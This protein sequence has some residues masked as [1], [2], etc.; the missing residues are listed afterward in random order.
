M[1]PIG[2]CAQ[3]ACIWET[4]ARNP[5][6]VHRQR[7]FEDVTY[8]DFLLSAAA[9]APVLETAGSRPVGET[10]LLGVMATRKVVQ[11]NTNLGILLLLAP[12]AAFS[13]ELSVREGIPRV[14]ET[15][16]VEDAVDVYRAIRLADP[17]GLGQ[18]AKQ[19]LRDDPTVNLREAMGLA[20]DRD[21]VARQY[22]NGFHEVLEVAL[23]ILSTGLAGAPSLE[24]ALVYCHVALLA[25][26][27][28]TLIMRKR[29]SS[30]AGLA[31]EL[32]QGLIKQLHKDLTFP[33][34]ALEELD[35]WL[36]A[37]GRGRNPGT[38]SDL[39][40]ACLFVALREGIIQLPPPLP[41][42]T[43]SCHG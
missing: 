7:D 43:G 13:R 29:G 28:D 25:E 34:A 21:L 37:A 1:V 8:L 16:T 30:E 42:S 32:A 6:N 17:A 4:S 15:L 20:A 38:T 27:P 23:P 39:V 26:F 40:T 9:I 14:L 2:L 19:D 36:R 35:R 31:A 18:V 41:W 24:A 22:A 12:L 3:L 11:R 33:E 5:G 10:V